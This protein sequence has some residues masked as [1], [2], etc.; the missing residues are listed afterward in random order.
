MKTKPNKKASAAA[1]ADTRDQDICQGEF[2]SLG[3]IPTQNPAKPDELEYEDTYSG[4]RFTLVPA[5]VWELDQTAT[6]Q[7]ISAAYRAGFLAGQEYL[8]AEFNE[9]HRLIRRLGLGVA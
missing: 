9:A 3:F 6:E 1:N 4:F 5:S 8:R 7:A 2:L